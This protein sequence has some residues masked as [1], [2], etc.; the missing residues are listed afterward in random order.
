[1]R[2]LETGLMM[3]VMHSIDKH[4]L[5]SPKRDPSQRGKSPVTTAYNTFSLSHFINDYEA[6]KE[7]SR[8]QMSKVRLNIKPSPPMH[9]L[10]YECT[11]TNIHK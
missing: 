3:R 4:R 5:K 6:K 7:A 1:M 8:N 11:T 10:D 9:I 2:K